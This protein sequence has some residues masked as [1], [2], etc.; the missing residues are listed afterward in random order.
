MLLVAASAIDLG[1]APLVD[2]VLAAR[3]NFIF[4]PALDCGASLDFSWQGQPKRPTPWGCI[5]A[6]LRKEAD[7]MSEGDGIL[8]AGCGAMSEGAAA[9]ERGEEWFLSGWLR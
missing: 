2:Q 6:M 9:T 8:K 3:I 7:P 5:A 4:S 1:E